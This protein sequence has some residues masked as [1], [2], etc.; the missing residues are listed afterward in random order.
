MFQTW[1]IQ[2]QPRRVVTAAAVAVVTAAAVVAEA[3]LSITLAQVISEQFGGDCF[4]D[5][6]HNIA[7][8]KQRLEQRA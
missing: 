3:M 8:Y 7:A 6:K 1:D 2:I 4:Q 5:L